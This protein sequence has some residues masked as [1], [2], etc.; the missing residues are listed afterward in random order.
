MPFYLFFSITPPYDH[1]HHT[2]YKGLNLSNI[3]SHA[4]KLHVDLFEHRVKACG[5]II[6]QYFLNINLFSFF[7]CSPIFFSSS[8]RPDHL[9]VHTLYIIVWF[10]P[11]LTC[12]S[13]YCNGLQ[14]LVPTF[15]AL[16]HYR[17]QSLQGLLARETTHFSQLR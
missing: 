6:M 13:L 8:S 11:F 15:I 14:T 12:P 3:A 7:C 1:T 5:N 16:Q 10:I 9:I 2:S 17:N 4:L